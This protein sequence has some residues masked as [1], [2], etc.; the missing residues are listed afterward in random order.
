MNE[1][2]LCERELPKLTFYYLGAQ[3]SE[4]FERIVQRVKKEGGVLDSYTMEVH[5]NEYVTR[6]QRE[7]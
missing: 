5:D 7:D 4:E 2:L 6:G 1:P 3:G